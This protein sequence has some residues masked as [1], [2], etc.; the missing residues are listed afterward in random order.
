MNSPLPVV[1]ALGAQTASRSVT[2]DAEPGV[3][4]PPYRVLR[5]VVAG[6]VDCAGMI[7]VLVRILEPRTVTV[8]AIGL[9]AE[10]EDG[11]L[12]AVLQAEF[13]EDAADVGS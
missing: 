4:D 1:G 11:C 13:G 3:G 7:C 8:G 6:L 5:R 9:V 2:A 10:G 12:D